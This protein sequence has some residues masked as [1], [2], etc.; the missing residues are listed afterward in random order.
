MF[1]YLVYLIVFFLLASLAYAASRGAPWVPTWKRDIARLLPLLNL[2]P[3]QKMYE[4]GCGDGRVC[5]AAAKGNGAEIV[6]VELSFLQWAIAELT[7]RLKGIRNARFV[8]GDI[9][10]QDLSDADV[11][12]IFL[13]PKFYEKLR[14]KFQ[15]EL[16]PG[17]RVVSYV[18]PIVGW[19]P[20]VVDEIAGESKIYVYEIPQ[21]YRC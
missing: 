9:F 17:A 21:A 5:L 2:K 11:V 10:K 15:K 6:G 4:L 7:R 8:W 1:L 16:R 18:W 19:N 3:G 20:L 14:P 12:Y 13:M